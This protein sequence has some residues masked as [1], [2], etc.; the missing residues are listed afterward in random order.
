M[1]YTDGPLR[2][3][4]HLRSSLMWTKAEIEASLDQGRVTLRTGEG[5]NKIMKEAYHMVFPPDDTVLLDGLAVPPWD[6]S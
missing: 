3:D 2:L 1:A 6:H 5:E 4:Q